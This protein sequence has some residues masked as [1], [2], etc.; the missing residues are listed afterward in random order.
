MHIISSSQFMNLLVGSGKH[1]ID[2]IHEL[3]DPLVQMEVLQTLEQVGVFTT[4]R[5]NHGDLLRFGLGRKD[6]YFKLERFQCHRLQ[7]VQTCMYGD[8]KE[9]GILCSLLCTIK[10]LLITYITY[11]YNQG[12][13][14]NSC[15]TLVGVHEMHS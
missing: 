13:L 14:C 6:S 5:A 7:G 9:C 11:M 10:Y 4:I 15:K 1:V 3:H 2:D 12:M 8:M